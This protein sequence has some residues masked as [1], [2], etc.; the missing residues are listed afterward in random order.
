MS[1]IKYISKMVSTIS[2]VGHAAQEGVII[3][4]DDEGEQGQTPEKEGIK[5]LPPPAPPMFVIEPINVKEGEY[6]TL[7]AHFQKR[8]DI[9]RQN[10]QLKKKIIYEKGVPS[11]SN[12]PHSTCN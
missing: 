10:K 8:Y 3:I 2:R 6:E 1:E 12:H 7:C 11:T 5:Y 9:T 4:S